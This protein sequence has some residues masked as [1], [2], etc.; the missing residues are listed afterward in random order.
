MTELQKISKEIVEI[1]LSPTTQPNKEQH[2][3]M[4]LRNESMDFW[5]ELGDKQKSVV[6]STKTLQFLHQI[7][8]KKI[9]IIK[10][11]NFVMKPMFDSC[12]GTLAQDKNKCLT[13]INH[14]YNIK[15]LKKTN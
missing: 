9:K 6:G 13:I 12:L 14:Q 3:S 1:W 11:N 15:I 2:E 5:I 8:K 10:K 4:M 7:T